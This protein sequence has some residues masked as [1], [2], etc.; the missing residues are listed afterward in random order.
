M[1]KI[2]MIGQKYGLLTVIDEAPSAAN[3]DAMWK[4]RCDCGNIKIVKGRHLRSG[5]TTSCGCKRIQ[6]LIENNHKKIKDLTNQKFG[7][8]IALYPNGSNNNRNIIWHCRCECGNECD[9]SSHDLITGN[10]KS[11]GCARTKSFGEEKIKKILDD[12][13]IFYI[14]EY[15]PSSLSF[16]GRFDFYLPE[17]NIIIEY[18]G[19]QHFQSGKGYF[20]N[21]EKF[22][23]TQEHDEIKTKWCKDNNILLIRIPYTKYETL[24]INDLIPKT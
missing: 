14:R 4:C 3:G 8:L 24:T 5:N 13:H 22:S 1:K 18:D 6:S 7:M 15:S 9:I 21:I 2:N 23:I 20:D 17:Q 11:C 19:I 16:K 12:A 10:T